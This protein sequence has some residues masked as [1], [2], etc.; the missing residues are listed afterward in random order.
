MRRRW[1]LMTSLRNLGARGGVLRG[2]RMTGALQVP[3]PRAVHE[4]V[5]ADGYPIALPATAIRMARGS[6]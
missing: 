5:T 6:S 4:V 3:E 1:Q 2:V